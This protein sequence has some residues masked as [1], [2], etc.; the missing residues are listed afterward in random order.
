MADRATVG[1][2]H[3][4]LQSEMRSTL[5]YLIFLEAQLW[6]DRKRGE[7]EPKPIA[8]PQATA[9]ERQ[10][11][12]VATIENRTRG[13]QQTEHLGRI[14]AGAYNAFRKSHPNEALPKE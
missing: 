12:H 9:G 10:R 4:N 13:K 8:Q 2:N 14:K 1:D 5:E 7:A 3:H 6:E 11:E